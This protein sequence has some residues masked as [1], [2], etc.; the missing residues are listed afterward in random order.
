MSGT[1]SSDGHGSDE[2]TE[3]PPVRRTAKTLPPL[4]FKEKH[5]LL[6]LR[7]GPLS[8]IQTDLEQK[9]GAGSTELYNTSVTTAAPF[10]HVQNRRA[11]QEFSINS[12]NGWKTALDKFRTMRPVRAENGPGSMRKAKDENDEDDVS[13]VLAS[14]KDDIKALWEDPTVKEMLNR[15]KVRIEDAP[16][17]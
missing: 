12:N 5:R 14:L 11:L 15:R 6:K 8:G 4:R 9:L 7:L 17:L 16:G 10:D 13:E 2:S 3:D 1:S